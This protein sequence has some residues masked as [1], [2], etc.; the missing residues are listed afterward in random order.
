MLKITLGG[1]R[2]AATHL[3]GSLQGKGE[4]ES[5]FISH[6]FQ[7]QALSFEVSDDSLV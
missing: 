7:N 4:L 3:P 6:T 2:S 5:M 1:G